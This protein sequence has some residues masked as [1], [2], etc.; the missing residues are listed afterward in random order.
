MQVTYKQFGGAESKACACHG[1]YK[2]GR[3]EG[4][5]AVSALLEEHSAQLAW[6][7]LKGLSGWLRL[8]L[9]RLDRRRR[10]CESHNIRHHALRAGM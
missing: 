8:C 10:L 2:H 1:W 7:L 4:K 6:L 5:G 3:A 9:C